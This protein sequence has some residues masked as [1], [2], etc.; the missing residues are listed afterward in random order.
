MSLFTG[1]Q[2][3]IRT[4]GGRPS[5]NFFSQPEYAELKI[6]LDA[7]MKRLKK[8]GVDATRKAAEVISEEQE[9]VLWEKKFLGDHSPQTLLDMMVFN[10]GLYFAL[11]SDMEHRATA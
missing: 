5:I 11:R 3:H 9:N 4:D 8:E 6:V 2:W 1:L 10:N 7:Q